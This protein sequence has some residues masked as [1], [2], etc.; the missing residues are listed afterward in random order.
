MQLIKM[1]TLNLSVV[2]VTSI[3]TS[4]VRC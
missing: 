4:K 1:W 3:D 2:S